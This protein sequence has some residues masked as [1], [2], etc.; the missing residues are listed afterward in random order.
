MNI[1]SLN[2]FKKEINDVRSYLLHIQYI[3]SIVE[4]PLSLSERTDIVNSVIQLKEHTRKFRTSKKIFEYKASI[5]SLYGILEKYIESWIKEYLISLS[6]IIYSYNDIDEKLRRENFDKSLS[7]MNILST[8]E[9]AKYQH[10]KKEEVLANLHNCIA[11]IDEYQLNIDAFVILSGNLKHNKIVD[12]LKPLNINLND[13]LTKNSTLNSSIGFQSSSHQNTDKNILYSKLNDLV[14][15]RN[16]IAHGSEISDILGLSELESYIE[17]LEVY[18]H[19]V[20]DVLKE[21]LIKLE[22]I[23]RFCQIESGN[24]INVFNDQILAVK[25]QNRKVSVGDFIVVENP[26]GSLIKK[27]ILEIQVNNVSFESISIDS[28]CNVGLRVDPSIKKNCKFYMKKF[29]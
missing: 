3:D 19:A 2:D 28:V 5:I 26:D 14:E 21:E 18:C 25:I 9:T 17:F 8:R 27:S 16:Y 13:G 10:L 11:N 24:V 12:L 15:R 23:H 29:F 6:K 4:C 7:L 20:F 22:I 1:E